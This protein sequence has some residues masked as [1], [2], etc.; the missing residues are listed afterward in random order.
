MS[1]TFARMALRI[2]GPLLA[3]MACFALVYVLGA[4][5]CVHQAGHERTDGSGLA[6]AVSFL[7]VLAATALTA[8]QIRGALQQRQR[9]CDQNTKFALFLVLGL[10]AVGLMGLALLALPL[11]AVHPACAGQPTLVSSGGAAPPY[12]RSYTARYQ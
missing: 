7:L 12:A 3:W 6:G 1:P 2:L 9:R 10:G 5:S 11:V 8:W 4:I